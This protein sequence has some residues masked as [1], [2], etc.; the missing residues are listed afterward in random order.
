MAFWVFGFSVGIRVFAM[1]LRQIPFFLLDVCQLDSMTST[2]ELYKVSI[3]KIN[4]FQTVLVVK[5]V[6]FRI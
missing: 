3:S 6:K 1:G 4:K 2:L 5:S